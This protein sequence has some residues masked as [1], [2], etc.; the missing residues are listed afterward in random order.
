MCAPLTQSMLVKQTRD[1][2]HKPNFYSS[3]G[4]IVL[5]L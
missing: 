2:D 5:E 1:Y 4:A 3:I